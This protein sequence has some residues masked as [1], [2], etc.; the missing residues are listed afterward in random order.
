MQGIE[1]WNSQV[2]SHVTPTKPIRYE[3]ILGVIKKSVLLWY[4][5]S[6]PL[7]RVCPNPYTHKAVKRLDDL[8]NVAHESRVIYIR[9]STDRLCLVS[10]LLRI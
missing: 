1:A 5:K 3:R 10:W 4:L 6:F 2:V 8:S 9:I 7:N